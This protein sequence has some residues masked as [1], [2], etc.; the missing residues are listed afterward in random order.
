V[1]RDLWTLLQEMIYL[2]FVVKKVNINVCPNLDG[3]GI[4]GRLKLRIEGKDF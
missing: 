2:G 1:I 3:Y 4:N